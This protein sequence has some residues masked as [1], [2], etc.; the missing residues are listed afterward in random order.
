MTCPAVIPR[1]ELREHAAARCAVTAE[2]NAAPGNPLASVPDQALVSNGNFHPVVPALAY[3]ALR[4]ALCGQWCWWLW[5]LSGLRRE[6]RDLRLCLEPP[7][8]GWL[9]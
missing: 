7:G 2:P 5:D 6:L 8:C 3:D 9:P 1:R 4:I